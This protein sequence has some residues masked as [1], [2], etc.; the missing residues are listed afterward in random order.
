[1]KLFLSY[2]KHSNH[3]IF[4][5]FIFSSCLHPFTISI[6]QPF[7]S[8][9]RCKNL[10]CN[11]VGIVT[12]RSVAPCLLIRRLRPRARLQDHLLRK[13]YTAA[14]QPR[15]YHSDT[16]ETIACRCLLTLSCSTPPTLLVYRCCSEQSHTWP[17]KTNNNLWFLSSRLLIRLHASIGFE[18]TSRQRMTRA[19][20]PDPVR[21]H[22]LTRMPP[23]GIYTHIIYRMCITSNTHT[24][25][26]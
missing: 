15:A 16:V 18:G 11:L 8:V 23:R 6:V 12:L 13:T 3:Y 14:A 20:L 24:H 21:V 9:L 26:H 17:V 7:L 25:T 2:Q 5:Y 10:I 19:V 4:K 22:R 1:M